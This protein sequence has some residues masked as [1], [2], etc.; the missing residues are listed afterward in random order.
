[1]YYHIPEKLMPKLKAENLLPFDQNHGVSANWVKLCL[2]ISKNFDSLD[3]GGHE[4]FNLPRVLWVK[5]RWS[6]ARLHQQIYRHFRQLFI[7]WLT[8]PI[9]KDGKTHKCKTPASYYLPV[10]PDWD[11]EKSSHTSKHVKLT[12]E[13]LT[14]GLLSLEEEY[15]TF[16]PMMDQDAVEWDDLI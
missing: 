6:L 12:P 2:L 9:A 10:P 4:R 13:H 7:N 3:K 11:F 16:F 8:N 14:N 15:A 1:M 5:K